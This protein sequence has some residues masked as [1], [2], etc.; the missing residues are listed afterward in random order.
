MVNLTIDGQKITVQD[1]TTIL[2][3]ARE[4][5]ID[6]P[7]FCYD[8][9]LTVTAACRMCV[10]EVA[11]ARNLPAACAT[12][13][14]EGMVIQTE[15]PRVVE[16]RKM[17]LDLLLANHPQDCLTCEKTGDCRLQDYC[18]RYGIKESSYKGEKKQIAI[19]SENHLIERDQNKCI[20][21]GKCVSVCREVQVTTAVDFIGRG[22]D[23]KVTPPFDLPLSQDSC[24]FCGQCVS[25]CP[26]GALTNKQFKGVRPWEVKKVQTTCPFCGVGCNFDLNVKNGKVVGV[27]PNA[28]APV[29][30]RSM[31]VK[32]RFHTD[33]I[34]SPDRITTP[35]IKK[36]GKFVEASW[37]EA[38]S[39]VSE[40]FKEIKARDGGDAIAALS[41]ARCTNEDNW[42]MQKF[43]RAV[44]GTNNVDHCART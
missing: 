32:G 17:N 34:Y 33:M 20:L 8:K 6:I 39:L 14:T 5:G 26:T 42:A 44:I 30:G 38:L 19:D 10:V 9:D 41:S 1:G 3:A 24:R 40:K 22:F 18:Y 13:V 16:S 15:S 12:P 4:L 27:T 2:E 36:E 21:C 7:N 43:M 35:L 25:M 31:C 11:G 28:D 37:E 29:N 23:T